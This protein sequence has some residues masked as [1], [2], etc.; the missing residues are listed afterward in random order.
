MGIKGNSRASP[1]FFLLR[2][3]SLAERVF[4]SLGIL[5]QY[6]SID[7]YLTSL[8]MRNAVDGSR[9]ESARCYKQARHSLDE[10][11]SLGCGRNAVCSPVKESF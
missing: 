4:F 11:T 8:T 5:A 2:T 1:F 7:A 9:D 10:L 3:V 6:R